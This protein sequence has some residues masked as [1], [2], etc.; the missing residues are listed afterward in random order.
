MH[1]HNDQLALVQREKYS[2]AAQLK[3]M[4]SERERR[5]FLLFSN[6]NGHGLS[7]EGRQCQ[8]F[9]EWL[10]KE[11]KAQC[12][13]NVYGPVGLEVKCTIPGAEKYLEQA[14]P[15][16]AMLGFVVDNDDDWTFLSEAK[17]K[18]NLRVSIGTTTSK[19]FPHL[20]KL[21]E[22]VR[23]LDEAIAGNGIPR[24]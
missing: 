24:F 23:F 7:A 16:R 4:Q 18:M 1:E 17:M 13:N 14:I 6:S 10:D 3:K 11:G 15:R 5:R 12:K 21:P 2:I 9:L 19:K 22:G 8:S 20:C